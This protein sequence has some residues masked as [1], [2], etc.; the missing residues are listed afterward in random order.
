MRTIVNS[1]NYGD[2]GTAVFYRWHKYIPNNIQESSREELIESCKSDKVQFKGSRQYTSLRDF[3]EYNFSY[4]I[5]KFKFNDTFF[6][7]LLDDSSLSLVG[8]DLDD[9]ERVSDVLFPTIT[10]DNSSEYGE[11][12]FGSSLISNQTLIVLD[13]DGNDGNKEGHWKIELYEEGVESNNDV[14][15]GF[16]EVELL[17]NLGI[18][19]T[20]SPIITIYLGPESNVSNN[21][22]D[23]YYSYDPMLTEKNNNDRLGSSEYRKL[24][25]EI[26]MYKVA[27]ILLALDDSSMSSINLSYRSW[28]DNINPN[29]NMKDYIIRNDE[30]YSTKNNLLTVEKL[31]EESDIL[32][33]KNSGTIVGNEKITTLPPILRGKL[34][35]ISND[36]SYSPYIKY[37][38]GDEVTFGVSESNR[39]LYWK[40]LCENNI[41]NIP[42]LSST[43]ILSNYIN[44]IFTS[45]I[46]IISSP[47][48]GGYTDPG[49][50]ITVSQNTAPKSFMIYCSIGYAINTETPV[51]ST[52]NIPLVTGEYEL[53]NN[54]RLTILN[55]D[56]LRS[57]GRLIF[58]FILIGC[59]ITLN[60]IDLGGYVIDYENWKT[61]TGLDEPNF[62]LSKL[63]VNDEEQ[64]LLDNFTGEL[65]LDPNSKITLIFP[66][67]NKYSISK[68]ISNYVRID[69][70]GTKEII[71]EVNENGESIITDTVD[72]NN[73][74]Y[75]LELVEKTL[76]IT[77]IDS[78]DFEISQAIGRVIYGD[79]YSVSFYSDTITLNQVIISSR[80]DSLTLTVA[81]INR[82]NITFGDSTIEF[83][84]EDNIYTISM[85]NVTVS[86]QISLN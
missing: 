32:I 61:S 78:E 66:E 34:A 60:A 50:S 77:M 39:P 9:L 7:N 84:V 13:A 79:D 69:Q 72:Y 43:W 26:N 49:N 55:W 83:T 1:N 25:E 85:S 2:I 81:D 48:N 5:K 8:K 21:S 76:T 58:N 38:L 75:S 4:D 57:S 52:S 62:E 29:R 10:E 73:T 19:I 24:M 30:Y 14:Y 18:E 36:N 27:W 42:T 56:K 35:K 70:T 15:G 54:N 65:T 31:N 45:R 12:F 23:M 44:S 11:T 46:S 63:L 33:D 80:N 17:E 37:S 67:L 64:P 74:T 47:V 86:S 82:D 22:S 3:S 68:V 59:S 53:S 40:S 16:I 20:N 71:P 6:I 28:I 41:G 51:S